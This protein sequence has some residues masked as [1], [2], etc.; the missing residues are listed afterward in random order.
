MSN[1]LGNRDGTILWCID[2]GQYAYRYCKLNW[3]ITVYQSINAVCKDFKMTFV[4]MTWKK[5]LYIMGIEKIISLL[6]GT[7][8]YREARGILI[9]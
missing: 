3:C 5:A 6:S 8:Y 9:L 7:Y 1:I 4:E 2:N